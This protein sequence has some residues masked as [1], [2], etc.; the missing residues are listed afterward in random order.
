MILSCLKDRIVF[1]KYYSRE[2]FSVSMTAW[3]QRWRHKSVAVLSR[4]TSNKGIITLIDQAVVSV[5]NFLTGVI[6]GRTCIKEEFG[7]YILGFSIVLFIVKLQTSLISTPYTVYFPRLK[8]KMQKQ[9]T[10][11]TLIHQLCISSLAVLFLLV[12]KTVLS[13]GI[14]PERL[15][16]IVWTLVLVISFILLREYA[17]RVC[18]A[19]LRI[20]TAILV[21]FCVSI[22]QIVGLLMLAHLG[23]L[24]ANKAYCVVGFACGLAAIGWLI[25]SRKQF[26]L[27][28]GG[29]LSDLVRNW[30]FGRWL[31]LGSLVYIGSIQLFPWFLTAFHGIAATGIL[32]ACM[33]VLYL[34]N[35]FLL[36]MQNFLGPKTAHAYVNGGVN[37]L[38]RVVRKA[39]MLFAV[40]MGFF[41][42]V[43]FF[44]GGTAVVL[45]Y[46]MKYGGSGLVVRVLA[47]NQLAV[48][49]TFPLNYGLLAMERP[50]VEFKSYILSL[51]V[52]LTLGLWL[53][54]LFGPTGAAFGL[55]ASNVV[56][57][58][59]RYILYKKQLCVL[60]T[61][62]NG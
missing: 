62:G 17:R 19:H 3:W 12:V 1:D 21:D 59:F 5:T 49:L 57:S 32:G 39:S 48:S 56:G 52:T 20:K 29:T 58:A 43:M 61:R 9:Y 50:D 55:L 11:S 25:L 34:A 30:S 53:V 36:G 38:K 23:V 31:F 16:P 54:K 8:D 6:I 47:L 27:C 33:G 60:S 2:N 46:G 40:I 14:G 42:V 51:F 35:P 26:I 37:E 7:L 24:S 13:V 28:L 4:A 44:F 41:F 18:F 22:M 10:G 15:E 45:I